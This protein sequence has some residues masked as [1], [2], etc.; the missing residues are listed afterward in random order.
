MRAEE[1]PRYQRKDQNVKLKTNG[2]KKALLKFPDVKQSIRD[3]KAI[4]N[5]A[6]ILCR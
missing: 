4:L 6:L 5:K 2:Y 3:H 1:D